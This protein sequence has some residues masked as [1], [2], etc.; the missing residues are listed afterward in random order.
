[1]GPCELVPLPC[2]S[3]VGGLG[4]STLQSSSDS[5]GFTDPRETVQE[6]SCGYAGEMG[7]CPPERTLLAVTTSIT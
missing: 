5:D 1:M 3:G 7:L 2:L 6:G 4:G